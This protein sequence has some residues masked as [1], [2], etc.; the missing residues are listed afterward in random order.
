MLGFCSD[1]KVS[2]FT[3]TRRKFFKQK[4]Q[5]HHISAFFLL[6]ATSVKNKKMSFT[7]NQN[8]CKS[9]NLTKAIMIGSGYIYVTV[10]RKNSHFDHDI[11][12]QKHLKTL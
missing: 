8:N 5:V 3:Q 7:E 9:K 1:I 2:A 4:F 10:S 6:M 11:S 12:V